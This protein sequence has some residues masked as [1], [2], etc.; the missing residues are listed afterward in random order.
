MKQVLIAIS[1]LFS[2]SLQAQSFA[3]VVK[4]VA[5]DRGE[6][7]RMGYAVTVYGNY[8]AVGAYGLDEG[9]GNPN[10]GAVYIYE[11]QGLNNWVEIQKLANADQEDYDRFG[12]SV[13][14]YGDF[15]VVGAYGEDDDANGNNNLSKAGS[16]YI[17]Q[18]IAG[19]WTQTQ[20]IVASD[21]AADDEFGWSV[22][23]YD[24]TIAVGAHIEDEDANGLNFK[25]HAGSVYMFELDG[26]GIWNQTQKVVAIDRWVDMVYPNG[27]SGEDLA[28]QF[29][30]TVDIWG[31]YMIVGAPHHDYATVGPQTGGL[32]S[33]GAAFIFERSGGVWTEVAKIQNSDR[34]SWDRFGFDVA[35]D[36]NVI[37]VNAFSEDEDENGNNALT[38][39]G[40]VYIFERNLGG[41]WNQVQKIVP[42][43]RT[44]G[45][46]FGV[47]LAID[48]TLL[49]LGCHSDDHDEFAG[50]LKTDAGS[51]YIF[52]STGGVWSQF[53]KID[54]SDRAIGDNFGISVAIYG[55]VVL[56]GSD[57]S[58]LDESSLNPLTD[59]GAAYFF[60]NDLCPIITNTINPTICSGSNYTV[61][62]SSYNSTGSYVDILTSSGGCDST[63]YTNLT[64]SPPITHDV[65]AT[66]CN[67]GIYYIF[68]VPY[69]TPGNYSIDLVTPSGCDSTVI[70]HLTMDPPITSSQNVSICWGESYS[71]GTSTYTT[72]GI[73]T[74]VVSATN[75]CDSAI[76]TNLIVQLPNDVSISQSNSILTANETGAT[77]QWIDC[78]NGNSIVG[79]TN[80][81][82]N[83]SQVGNYAVIVTKNGCS[84][85]S[86]CVHVSTLVVGLTSAQLAN[87][88]KIFPNPSQGEFTIQVSGSNEIEMRI[89]AVSGEL[90]S[91]ETL[92]GQNIQLKQL[93]KGIYLA[94]FRSETDVYQEKIVIE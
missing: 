3:E 43:D 2:I 11:Q 25:Y 20:K 93:T 87:S 82:F 59:A 80:Q 24:S 49:V 54:A 23:I 21:R 55:T 83:A 50:D 15:L 26:T 51:A 38:N 22:A 29:G 67:G 46:H 85:T 69:T 35:I 18:N 66:M 36:S 88:I 17:F 63:V 10:V 65:Y 40:S 9:A 53:Q 33:S 92:N 86:A 44:S 30:H 57:S 73:Y 56:V 58:D 12:W 8:A 61:G 42:N 74:D 27:Y 4:S 7:D 5:S 45:D 6:D 89:Y 75:F 19:T 62:S 72:S 76:T 79:A 32:W 34:E 48:D 71:I 68:G 52:K 78:E 64:V 47:S 37:A 28:D 94:E 91:Q 81:V 70:T 60:N 90:I 16:A 41:A 77:Y 84:D 14:M 13:D 1:F 31:D 39:P